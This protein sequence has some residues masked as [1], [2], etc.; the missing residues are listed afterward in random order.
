M[1]PLGGALPLLYE[2]VHVTSGALV[3]HV[4]SF[5]SLCSRTSQYCGTF[6][7][8]SVSLWNDLDDS[9]FDCVGLLGFKSSFKTDSMFSSD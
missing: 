5:A 9:V 8:L 6:V 4:H 2:P 1:H 7:P 3:A